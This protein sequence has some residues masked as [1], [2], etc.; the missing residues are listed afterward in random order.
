[1]SIKC[2][3]SFFYYYLWSGV[4]LNFG[5]LLIPYNGIEAREGGGGFVCRDGGGE[6]RM[7]EDEMEEEG[8]EG[9]LTP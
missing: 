1:M 7:T 5:T 4:L 6:V 2:N 3:F 9:C 8:V